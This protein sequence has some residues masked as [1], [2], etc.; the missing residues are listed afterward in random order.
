MLSNGITCTK[1]L[2]NT[3]QPEVARKELSGRFVDAMSLESNNFCV[4]F[5]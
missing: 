4:V 2:D 5:F 1:P 3:R